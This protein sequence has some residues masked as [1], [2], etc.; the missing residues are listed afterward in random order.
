MNGYNF[1]ERVRKVLAMAREQATEFRHEYVGT[2]HILLGLIAEGEGVA[3]TVLQNLE[4]DL[5]KLG[6]TV[7]LI[8]KKGQIGTR[9]GPDLPYTSRAKKV[10]EF[11]M[12]EARELNHSYVGTEH[13]LLGLLREEKGI[14]AQ[15][16]TD[17]GATLDNVRSETLR[18]LGT[19]RP[20][21][22][23]ASKQKSAVPDSFKVRGTPAV[24]ERL[25][26][27]LEDAEDVATEFHAAE[28]TS[29][30]I[31]IAL[32]R[33]G[34]GFANAVLDRL[35]CDRKALVGALEATAKADAPSAM[36]E[37][38]ARVGEYMIALQRHIDREARWRSSPPGTLHALLSILDTQRDVASVFEMQGL[39]ANRVRTEA[40]RMSG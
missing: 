13:L 5:N 36:P 30:H 38:P 24:S 16:L 17:T 37:Q 39:T 25:R 19:E 7:E 10:L 29:V 18:I 15:V 33:H 31:A 22:N 9:T 40:R 11:A 8:V 2:E 23:T 4:I 35:G 14:A 12:T 34:E 27:V 28:L 6:L 20:A 21:G 32:V 1:T 26:E 3:A